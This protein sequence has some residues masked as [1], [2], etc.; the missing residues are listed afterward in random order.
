MCKEP[1]VVANTLSR[2]TNEEGGYTL[3]YKIMGYYGIQ[4]THTSY[5]RYRRK[6]EKHLYYCNNMVVKTSMVVNDIM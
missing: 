5:R 4:L 6:G 1:E 3:L 2:S